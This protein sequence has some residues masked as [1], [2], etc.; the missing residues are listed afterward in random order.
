MSDDKVDIELRAACQDMVE[1]LK[2]AAEHDGA[3]VML[4]TSTV[5]EIRALLTRAWEER[6][7]EVSQDAA[8][9][10]VA[11][12]VPIAIAALEALRDEHKA[13]GARW[14]KKRNTKEAAASLV[15]AAHVEQAM[16]IVRKALEEAGL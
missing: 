2:A 5:R 6:P 7:E 16:T 3:T 9:P 12:D 8:I 1:R 4:R 14:K 10:R 13:D 11:L 15:A